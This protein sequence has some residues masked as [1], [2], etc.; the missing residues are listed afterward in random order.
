[1]KVILNKNEAQA[2]ALTLAEGTFEVPMKL[3]QDKEGISAAA[4]RVL[5]PVAG[6]RMGGVWIKKG[7]SGSATGAL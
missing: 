5:Y 4:G 6:V 7:T 3:T 2:V 1:M